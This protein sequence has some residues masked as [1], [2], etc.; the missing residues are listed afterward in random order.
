[1]VSEQSMTTV[2]LLYLE[3]KRTQQNNDR[4][5]VLY[6]M[7]HLLVTPKVVPVVRQKK[8]VSSWFGNVCGIRSYVSDGIRLIMPGR[9]ADLSFVK[10]GLQ[11]RGR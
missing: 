3:M 6:G 1:M 5:R 7:E 11:L 9:G 2:A 4:Y 10:S 8:R